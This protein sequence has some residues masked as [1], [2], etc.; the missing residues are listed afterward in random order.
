VSLLEVIDTAMDE[1]MVEVIHK[2]IMGEA[3]GKALGETMVE[4]IHDG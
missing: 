2:A 3:L 4:A 1:T